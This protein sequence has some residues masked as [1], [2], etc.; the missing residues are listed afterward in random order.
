MFNASGVLINATLKIGTSTF[1]YEFLGANDFNCTYFSTP[2][3]SNST[4]LL[5]FGGSINLTPIIV[6]ETHGKSVIN[7]LFDQGLITSKIFAISFIEADPFI[8]FGEYSNAYVTN[9]L[10]FIPNEFS[11]VWGVKLTSF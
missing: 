3:A 7:A 1:Q 2:V 10:M 11:N 4:S 9:T 6:N 8:D 5:I